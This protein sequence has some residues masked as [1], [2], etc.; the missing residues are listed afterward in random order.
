MTIR[1]ATLTRERAQALEQ[2]SA[3]EDRAANLQTEL[4]AAA[5]NCKGLE[6][7]LEALSAHANE[8][9]AQLDKAKAENVRLT[10]LLQEQQ[11]Q[12]TVFNTRIEGLTGEGRLMHEKLKNRKA[13]LKAALARIAEVDANLATLTAENQFQAA[14]LQEA[15][16]REAKLEAEMVAATQDYEAKLDQ[17]LR[18]HASLQRR[19]EAVTAEYEANLDL[20]QS[21][22][23]FL[24]MGINLHSKV[25]SVLQG[26]TPLSPASTAA[27]SDDSP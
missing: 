26:Q 14:K 24:G 25:E 10:G 11:E 2:V 4:E 7:K 8:L 22:H 3:S 1:I 19:T 9:Q 17:S 13:E 15:Q 18:Q 5:M 20:L 16:T 21:V 12:V 27:V 6:D 23:K